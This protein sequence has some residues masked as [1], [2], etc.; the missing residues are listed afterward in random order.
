MLRDF[1]KYYLNISGEYIGVYSVASRCIAEIPKHPS[2]AKADGR[3]G[4]D[5]IPRS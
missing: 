2:Y 3:R 4:R 5:G 1:G